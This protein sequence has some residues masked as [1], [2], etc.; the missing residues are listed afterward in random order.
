MSWT[1]EVCDVC[2]WSGAIDIVLEWNDTRYAVCTL[3]CLLGWLRA[4]GYGIEDEA[5]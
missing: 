3:S 4:Q 2:G 5:G 1:P